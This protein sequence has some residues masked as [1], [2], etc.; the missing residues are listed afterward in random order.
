MNMLEKNEQKVVGEKSSSEKIVLRLVGLEE[1]VLLNLMMIEQLMLNE[2]MEIY[3][4]YSRSISTL[5]LF[6][7]CSPIPRKRSDL[8]IAANSSDQ[9]GIHIGAACAES[10]LHRRLDLGRINWEDRGDTSRSSRAQ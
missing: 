3:I 8:E 2:P 6:I 4:H 10:N 9:I 7:R 1:V 5:S